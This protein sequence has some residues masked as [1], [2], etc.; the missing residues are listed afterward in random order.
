[1]YLL[2]PSPRRRNKYQRTSTGLWFSEIV[3]PMG[4]PRLRVTGE[5]VHEL[6]ESLRLIRFWKLE[7]RRSGNEEELRK[8]LDHW[9]NPRLFA[10]TLRAAWDRYAE[11]ARPS[12]TRQLAAYWTHQI[13]PKLGELAIAQLTRGRM[14]EWERWHMTQA[15]EGKGYAPKTTADAFACITAAVRRSLRDG[16]ALPWRIGQGR[17]WHPSRRAAPVAERPACGSVEEAE[18]IVAAA[19]ED[20]AARRAGEDGRASW[21]TGNLHDLAHRCA[22]ALLLALRNGEISGLGWDDLVLGGNEPRARIRHQAIDQ[23]RTFHPE[24]LRPLT[25]PKGGRERTVLIH[26]T[27]LLA[28]LAQRDQLEARGWYRADGPVF[29]G[30]E[31]TEFAGGWRNNANGI[32][33]YELKRLAAAAGLPFPDEWVT[34]SLRHSLATIESVSGAELRSIQKRTGHGSLR[35]L[36]HYIHAR[37]GRGLAPS[38]V[39]ALQVSFETHDTDPAPPPEED[40]DA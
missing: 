11:A 18:R 6:E 13:A 20:D 24:W 29:P 37:T 1:M 15:N 25:P 17:S 35:V 32:P 31:G 27:A 34:H 23:W 10:V 5:T 4:G 33:P 19:L 30:H 16:Q 26:P 8:K 9:R 39:R 28:L 7:W 3:D 2:Q 22:V 21:K 36:E 38:A 12:R 40:D 14:E